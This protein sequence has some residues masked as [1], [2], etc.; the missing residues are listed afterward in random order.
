MAKRI[1][2]LMAV[3]AASEMAKMYLRNE[4]KKAC[5]ELTTYATNVVF[6]LIPKEVLD[7][8]K[9]YS[10]YIYGSFSTG[11]FAYS[12]GIRLS[13]VYTPIR[14]KVPSGC[15]MLEVDNDT[16]KKLAELKTSIVKLSDKQA[17]FREETKNALYSLGT[18]DKIE[19]V[20][21]NAIKYI[22][23]G[24]EEKK[25]LPVSNYTNLQ[26]IITTL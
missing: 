10:D 14:C 9:K 17:K 16:Y 25:S 8:T 19:K 3:N 15:D 4:K 6:A 22:D 26:Q 5:E 21:P 11:F 20:F 2:K 24:C 7:T 1:T 12:E 23:F 18:K 13:A